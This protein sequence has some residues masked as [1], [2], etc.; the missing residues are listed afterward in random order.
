MGIEQVTT[1]LSIV[2]VVE[3]QI[4]KYFPLS[5]LMEFSLLIYS[6]CVP[7]V[8]YFKSSSSASSPT[9]T[10]ELPR[11]KTQVPLPR[12]EELSS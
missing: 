2:I 4:L 12:L 7:F 10:P 9:P 1:V 3:L 5:S 8:G 6:N 11:Q